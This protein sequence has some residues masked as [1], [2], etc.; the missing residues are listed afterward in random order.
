MIYF[1]PLSTKRLNVQLR[2]LTIQQA[3]DLAATPIGRHEVTTQRFITS[4]VESSTGPEKDPLRW[5]VEE[6]MMVLAHYLSCVSEEGANF[7]LGGEAKF[8][9]FLHADGAPDFGPEWVAVGE[10]C[11]SEWRAHQVNGAQARAMEG[12]CRSQLDWMFAELAV[13]MRPV[14]DTKPPPDAVDEPEQFS[15]WLAARMG[16]VKALPESDFG[17][18]FVLLRAGQE[19]LRH[20]FRVELD[21][22]G[23]FAVSKEME[24]GRAAGRFLVSSAVTDLARRLRDFAPQ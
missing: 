13:R 12:A 18:L 4:V 10:A 14:D 16:E 8:S 7:S 17:V 20:I 19:Q 3:I 2:E 5:T 9:D 6:R 15:E 21:A 23:F 24:G 22:E 11:G 1:P